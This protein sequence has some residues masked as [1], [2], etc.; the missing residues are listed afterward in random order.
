M[1]VPEHM[2]YPECGDGLFRRSKS[3]GVYLM[4]SWIRILHTLADFGIA[5]VM[6]LAWRCNAKYPRKHKQKEESFDEAFQITSACSE[7]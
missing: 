6:K 2:E 5:K 1:N 7:V 3:L 4:K